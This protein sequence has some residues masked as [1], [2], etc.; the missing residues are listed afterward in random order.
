MIRARIKDDDAGRITV[1]MGDVGRR[2]WDYQNDNQ[3]RLSLALAW[4][5]SDGFSYGRA[6][7]IYESGSQGADLEGAA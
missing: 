6:A 1:D 3:R 2:S 7:P 5:F 4:A